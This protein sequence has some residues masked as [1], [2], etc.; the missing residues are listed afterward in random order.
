MSPRPSLGEVR[1]PHIL[2]AAADTIAERGLSATRVADIAA[3]AGTSG[4]A[5]LY[6][7]QSKD[8]LLAQALTF[9][10]DA[11]YER[12][13]ARLE[14]LDS[15]RERLRLVVL[16]SAE[17]YDWT[18]WMELWVHALRDPATARTRQALDRRWRETIAEIVRE[19]HARGEFADADP[20]RVALLVACLLDG[21]AVQATLGDPAVGPARMAS[22]AL[23][24]AGAELG[25]DLGSVT[26]G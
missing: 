21:L 8:D 17:D 26:D 1:R 18:L 25:C 7:F 12:L 16:A 10:E 11:F 15:A 22:L 24:L 2:G 14:L 3:R 9:A 4:P 20:E 19:G 6:W 23:G 13:A 5:L